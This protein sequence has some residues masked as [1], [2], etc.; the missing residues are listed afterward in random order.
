MD[1]SINDLLSKLKVLS[2]LQS[3]Q[4]LMIEDMR[5]QIM[6]CDK[7]NWDRFLKW[8]LGETRYST[9][10]KLQGFYLEIKDLITLLTA[11][12]NE[13]HKILE[14][15]YG[16]LTAAMRGLH[17]L[18]LTYQEDRTIV[19]QLETLTENFNIEIVRIENCLNSL[20]SP[21]TEK[22]PVPSPPK[23]PIQN[24]SEPPIQ[25][26]MNV[27]KDDEFSSDYSDSS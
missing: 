27:S 25:I 14:R 2:K 1:K 19:S 17:N 15:I 13:Q 8:W 12:S 26:K 3:G 21:K 16:E 18:M 24:E 5:I 20:K 7:N 10:D 23:P 11:R 6:E 22:F 4:K 9:L